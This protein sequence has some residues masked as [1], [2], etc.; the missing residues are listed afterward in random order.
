M[1]GS[2]IGKLGKFF[3]IIARPRFMTVQTPAHVHH[4]RVP[5]DL[6][7]RHITMTRLAVQSCRNLRPVDEMNKIRYLRDGYPFNWL[8]ILNVIDQDSQFFTGLS[9]G[10]LL[11]APPTFCLRGQ[12]G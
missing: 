8:V 5:G 11:M 12:A 7:L 4:L 9:L 1:T 3:F 10:Y 6:H 2:T